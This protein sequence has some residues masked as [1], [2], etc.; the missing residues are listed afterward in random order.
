M[1][2]E[3]EQ[4]TPGIKLHNTNQ[5]LGRSLT[6][7]PLIMTPTSFPVNIQNIKPLHGSRLPRRCTQDTKYENWQNIFWKVQKSR[8]AIP[9]DSDK[10]DAI[11]TYVCSMRLYLYHEFCF[12]KPHFSLSYMMSFSQIQ[13]W[14]PKATHSDMV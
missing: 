9:I 6:I 8:P 12:N 13:A 4:T 14:L 3:P 10:T 5:D 2:T 11:Q 7:T 1:Q